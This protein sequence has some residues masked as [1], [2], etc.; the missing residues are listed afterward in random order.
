MFGPPL[1]FINC[2]LCHGRRVGTGRDGPD[3]V[4]Q[5]WT[6]GERTKTKLKTKP[7]TKQIILILIFSINININIGINI[8]I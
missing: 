5:A 2:V 3:W 7:K 8:N 1:N 6:A 4:E